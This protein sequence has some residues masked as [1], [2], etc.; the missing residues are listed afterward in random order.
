MLF[1]DKE[2]MTIRDHLIRLTEAAVFC[3]HMLETPNIS[4]AD[5]IK[6]SH[7]ALYDAMAQVV[8]SDIANDFEFG[9]LLDQASRKVHPFI[10]ED[11]P[12]KQVHSVRRPFRA[13][14]HPILSLF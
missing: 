7:K 1:S 9:F 6:Q 10:S 4:G 12:P 13:T 14:H 3:M 5:R 2:S 11:N 8:D